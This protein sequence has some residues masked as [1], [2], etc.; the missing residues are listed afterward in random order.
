[1]EQKKSIPSEKMVY[2]WVG[3]GIVGAILL[4]VIGSVFFG[5]KPEPSR[6]TGN[7][8]KIDPSLYAPSD[9]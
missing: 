7:S 1:M 5:L 2:V 4:I 3:V 9:Y 8:E 6:S